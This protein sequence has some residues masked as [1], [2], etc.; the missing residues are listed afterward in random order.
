MAA[1]VLYS[2]TGWTVVIEDLA[3]A[4]AEKRGGQLGVALGRLLPKG[5]SRESFAGKQANPLDQARIAELGRFIEQGQKETGVPGVALGLVQDGKVIFADGFGV[6]ELG[7]TGEAGWRD[8][9]HDR[10]EHQGAH[11]AD[12]GKAGRRAQDELGYAGHHAVIPT[13][14]WATQRRPRA[15]S[16][17]S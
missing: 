8:A 13:S 2:G 3:D 10:I 14:S 17:S 11:H 4:V 15:C 6:K 16:S 12:A 5:Y 9:V 7:G 1:P